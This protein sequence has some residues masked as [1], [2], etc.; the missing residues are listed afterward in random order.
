MCLLVKHFLQHCFHVKE[1]SDWLL[2]KHI[3][4]LTILAVHKFAKES[5]YGK[6]WQNGEAIFK[7]WFPRPLF[8]Y[9]S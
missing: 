6:K 9:I 8:F 2:L 4:K 7:R 3:E 5:K 1:K